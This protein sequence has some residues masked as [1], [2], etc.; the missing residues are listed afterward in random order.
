MLSDNVIYHHLP[1]VGNDGTKQPPILRQTIILNEEFCTR[2]AFNPKSFFLNS[3]DVLVDSSLIKTK[4]IF[5]HLG[6]KFR[7]C[8]I[9]DNGN[10]TP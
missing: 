7:T 1:A 3:A 8:F 10:I 5:E 4:I 9:N 2:F 6:Y